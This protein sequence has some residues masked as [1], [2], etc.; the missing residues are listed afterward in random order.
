MSWQQW[1]S[2]DWLALVMFGRTEPPD[3]TIG[4]PHGLKYAF[5]L[6]L[7]AWLLM[8][9]SAATLPSSSGSARGRAAFRLVMWIGILWC[10]IELSTSPEI[11]LGAAIRDLVWPLVGWNLIVRATDVCVV[12]LGD[13]DPHQRAPRCIVPESQKDKYP[14][15]TKISIEGLTQK[16]PRAGQPAMTPVCESTWYVVPHT[17]KAFSWRRLLWAMDHLTLIRP[18]TSLLIPSEQRSLE[19]SKHALIKAAL[20]PEHGSNRFGQSEGPAYALL[21]LT[22]LL[23]VVVPTLNHIVTIPQSR[24]GTGADHFYDLPFAKQL[25]LPLC[26]GFMVPLSATL[27]ECWLFPLLLRSGLLPRTALVSV[28]DRPL[29]S[30]GLTDFWGRRWH[31]FIRRGVWRTGFLVPGARSNPWISR[32]S[33]FAV[34]AT[35]H[36]W[37]MVKWLRPLPPT[38][39]HAAIAGLFLPGPMALFLGQGAACA[40]EIFLLGKYDEREPPWKKIVRKVWLWSTLLFMGRWYV[41]TIASLGLNSVQGQAGAIPQAWGLR[42]S[43]IAAHGF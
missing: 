40:I 33:A 22:L 16:Q 34:S 42:D 30:N 7:A 9:A 5:T 24:T 36:S 28:F 8:L 31:A 43:F 14:G 17:E 37:M 23:A 39:L 12:S 3:L 11:T 27:S 13:V 32:L 26:Y 29:W 35:L 2:L 18:G 1:L 41:A 20:D 10:S 21:Q 25:L 4:A 38:K 6:F 19:W 15:T